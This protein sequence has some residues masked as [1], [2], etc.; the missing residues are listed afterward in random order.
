MTPTG[1]CAQVDPIPY[2][3]R[4]FRCKFPGSRDL[5]SSEHLWIDIQ[6]GKYRWNPHFPR[7]WICISRCHN[8]LD[9]P[10]LLEV[11]PLFCVQPGTLSSLSAWEQALEGVAVVAARGTDKVKFRLEDREVDY[12]SSLPGVSGSH[13]SVVCPRVIVGGCRVLGSLGQVTSPVTPST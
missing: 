3:S 12:L 11:L 10:V 9:I 2:L 7:T 13:S 8:D 5:F 4:S 1:V 6:M